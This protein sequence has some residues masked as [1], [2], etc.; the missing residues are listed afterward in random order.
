MSM[1]E[2]M[3]TAL[4]WAA[5]NGHLEMVRFLVE[6]AA[7]VNARNNDGW[8]ALTLDQGHLEVVRFLVG[9]AAEVNAR[10][11]ASETVLQIASERIWK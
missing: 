3:L 7:D 8:T 6:N 1:P 10:N 5:W 2:I 4:I 9:N 11:N